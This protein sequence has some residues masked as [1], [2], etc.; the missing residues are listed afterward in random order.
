MPDP[1]DDFS[2]F[3]GN[4]HMFF[5]LDDPFAFIRE[6]LEQVL[7]QQVPSTRIEAIRCH[8]EPKFLTLGRK[9]ADEPGQMIVTH[10]ASCFQCRI[11]VHTDDHDEVLPA[12]V[13]LC[14]GDIDEPGAERSQLFLHIYHDAKP[15]YEDDEFRTRFLEFRHAEASER[16]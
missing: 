10:Y 11:T 4:E 7:Q 1:R 13:T 5:N 2:P 14:V 15:A 3:A 16:A 9:L 12:T 8:D 6:Q